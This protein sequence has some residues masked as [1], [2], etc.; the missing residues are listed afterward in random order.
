LAAPLIGA[1]GNIDA[2]AQL[3]VYLHDDLHGLLLER[4]RVHL[5]PRRIEDLAVD[6]R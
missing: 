2:A 3:A 1:H 4:L 5:R 6:A